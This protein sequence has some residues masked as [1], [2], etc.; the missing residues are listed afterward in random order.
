MGSEVAAEINP[1]PKLHLRAELPILLT[2]VPTYPPQGGMQGFN[3]GFGGV[4]RIFRKKVVFSTKNKY[5]TPK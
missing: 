2:Y 3:W 5:T 4:F 1:P